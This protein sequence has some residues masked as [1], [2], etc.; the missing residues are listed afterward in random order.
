MQAT[1]QERTQEGQLTRLNPISGEDS[2]HTSILYQERTV[3]TP[4]SYIKRGQW[5]HLNP[6]SGEDSGHTSILCQERTVNTPQ[7]WP[8]ENSEHTSILARSSE[9][10]SILWERN[11]S[12]PNNGP[13]GVQDSKTPSLQGILKVRGKDGDDFEVPCNE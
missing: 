8:G 9:H 7:S 5:T 10:T 11:I 2:G 1:S 4:Q 6:I 12:I 3:D 13:S